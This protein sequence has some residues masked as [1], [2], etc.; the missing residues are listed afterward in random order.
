MS[1]LELHRS[2]IDAGHVIPTIL[3]TAYPYDIDRARARDDGVVCYLAR[4]IDEILLM[5]CLH[6]AFVLFGVWSLPIGA[7]IR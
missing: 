4:S 5:E 3:V 6:K 2:L 7:I 1:G